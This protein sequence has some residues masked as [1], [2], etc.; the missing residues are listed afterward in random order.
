MSPGDAIGAS[1]QQNDDEF[2]CANYAFEG[3]VLNKAYSRLVLHFSPLL[4]MKIPVLDNY[5]RQ[6]DGPRNALVP[7]TVNMFCYMAKGALQR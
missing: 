3:L 1:E 2:I 6:N 5:G 7:G 4:G